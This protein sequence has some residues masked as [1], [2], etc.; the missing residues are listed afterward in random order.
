MN[1]NAGTIAPVNT[2]TLL[3]GINDRTTAL[4]NATFMQFLS[5][6]FGLFAG[7]VN[8]L[9]LGE[10]EF[11][12][13]YKTQFINTAFSFPLTT[14]LVPI[15]AFGGGIIVLPTNDITLSVV[16]LDPDGTPTNNDLGSAFSDGVTLLGSGQLTVKPFGLVGHQSLGVIWSDK[17]RL[18]LSQDPDNI[19]RLLLFDLFPRLADPGP[20]LDAIFRRF[21]PGLLVPTQPLNHEASGWSMTYGFDQYFWQPDGN[22]K[23]GIGLF[24]RSG[25][26]TETQ[27]PCNTHTLPGSAAKAWCLGAPTTALVSASPR[28]SSAAHSFHSCAKPSIWGWSVRTHSRLIT[29]PRLHHGSAP[30]RIFRSLIRAWTKP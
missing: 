7:K 21:F 22:P 14:L 18:S 24:F 3:P 10:T 8:M 29:M 11:Y 5:P 23:H 9:D 13:D 6:Q 2:G 28:R 17:N 19:A 16:A 27:I 1:G 26:R 20:V 30:R 25:P 12:G 4:M 15:S